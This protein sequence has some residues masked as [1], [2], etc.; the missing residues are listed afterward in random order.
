MAKKNWFGKS[1]RKVHYMYDALEWVPGRAKDWNAREV[2]ERL[3]NAAVD[4]VEF[5]TKSLLGIVY[6]KSEAGKFVGKDLL[7]EFI[8]E[9]HKADIKVIAH[10][11]IVYDYETWKNNPTWRCR[12]VQGEDDW[13]PEKDIVQDAYLQ[14]HVRKPLCLNSPF[15]NY[16]ARELETISR[17]YEID[18]FW[19]DIFNSLPYLNTP[20]APCYC[21]Y[22]Q[23]KYQ[24]RY[25]EPMPKDLDSMTNKIKIG[26]FY[27]DLRFKLLKKY[28]NVIKKYRPEALVGLNN[29]GW[30]HTGPERPL[31][32]RHKDIVQLVDYQT[33]ESYGP[34][35][36][37][38][39]RKARYMRGE[40]ENPFEVLTPGCTLPG[41]GGW[42]A[43]P[44]ELL[45]IEAAVV[46]SNGGS[47]T[48]GITPNP[49]G[50][51]YEDQLDN[52]GATFRWLKERE[53]FLVHTESVSD[54]ALLWTQHTIAREDAI[55]GFHA[56][57]VENHFQFDIRDDFDRLERYRLVILPDRICL[58]QEETE[59]IKEYV[60]NGGNLIG[61]G[62]AT[63]VD[64]N[65]NLRDNFSL[66]E[67]FG[68]NFVQLAP[69]ENCYTKV[70]NK[71][72][73]QNLPSIIGFASQAVE[74]E[75]TNGNA[76]SFLT[77]PIDN[78]HRER[79]VPWAMFNPPYQDTSLPFLV[80]NS[81]GNG[82]SVY[83][84]TYIG[85][86]IEK[87]RQMK[88]QVDPWPKVLLS[89]IVNYL[90]PEPLIIT[91]APRG[92]EIVLNRKD[93]KYII[94]LINTYPGIDGGKCDIGEKRV[95]LQGINLDINLEKIGNKK[96]V[97]L[98]PSKESVK[99]RTD[100]KWLRM[101]IPTLEIHQMIVLE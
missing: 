92:I 77:Y 39:S 48:V 8:E 30:S 11:G 73:A 40:G 37:E 21:S 34:D 29:E 54:I 56:V 38:Q 76:L 98:Y 99:F 96:N 95:R 75:L 3:K 19:L 66:S 78:V 13:L 22:C 71:N 1:F 80:K 36:L 79:Y 57:L 28:V 14:Y 59:K 32:F 45:K 67:V 46:A 61:A 83:I 82:N 53:S 64:E 44:L 69:Y 16:V 101:D 43:K 60:K 50:K 84:A 52:I 20:F 27:D 6:Y 35:F 49:L 100:N 68:C 93:K 15:Q 12:N 87:V 26:K 86:D 85:E 33:L 81:Y 42:I 63:L 5:Y 94:N 97:Y 72:I 17:N 23:E 55:K 70:N 25:G 89:N 74:V 31:G 91:N 2:I 90:L 41:Y 10:F 51:D 18:G 9:A 65:Y 7:K 62:V 4:T 88:S 58:N 47:I 24:K